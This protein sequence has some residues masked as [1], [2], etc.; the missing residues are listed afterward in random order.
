MERSGLVLK[1]VA[2]L[3]LAMATKPTHCKYYSKT[4]PNIQHKEK[5]THLH[6]YF[7]NFFS[8]TKP[9]AVEIARPELTRNVTSPTPFGSLIASDDP[10]REGTETNSTVIG[11]AR[12]MYLSSS[13]DASHM[14][15]I[16]YVDFGF[17][18]GKFNGSSFAVFSRNPIWETT[19]REVAVVGGRGKFRLAR[20]FAKLRTHY[21]N[22]S[23]GDAIVEYRVTLFHY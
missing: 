15:L 19:P 17:T 4:I 1:F 23:N 14:T 21:L 11:N 20:G 18:R 7:F 5:V 12:G 13:Q 2:M 10:L 9:S 6:F 3:L 22:V 8:G 16:M